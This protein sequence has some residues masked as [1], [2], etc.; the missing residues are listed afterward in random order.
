MRLIIVIV[1]LVLG[2]CASTPPKNPSFDRTWVYLDEAERNSSGGVSNAIKKAKEQLAAAEQACI[3]NT[4]LVDQYA[5]DIAVLQGKADYWREKQRKA[6]KELWVWRGLL[7][8]VIIFAARGPI[9]W[10]IRKLVGIPW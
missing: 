7:I 9:L 1:S 3:G 4:K 10:G 6:L 8:G 2:G 5:K